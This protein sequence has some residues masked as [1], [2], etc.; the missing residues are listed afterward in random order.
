[1]KK[2]I[3]VFASEDERGQSVGNI[4]EIIDGPLTFD[5]VENVKRQWCR[6]TGEIRKTYIDSGRV[7]VLNIIAMEA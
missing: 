4:Y 6:K 7:S 3:F 2:Y 5:A 1:M